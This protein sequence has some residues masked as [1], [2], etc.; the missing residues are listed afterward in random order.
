MNFYGVVE[1]RNDPEKRGRLKV[2]VFSKM[3]GLDLSLIPWCEPDYSN[4]GGSSSG[5]GKFDLPELNSVVSVSYDDSLYLP[6]WKNNI[7]ISK[8]LIEI[9]GEEYENAVSLY[10]NESTDT[11]SIMLPNKGIYSWF[12]DAS[13]LIRNDGSVLVKSN[14]QTIHVNDGIS[15][16]SENKSAQSGV[17]GENNENVLNKMISL[18]EDLINKIETYSSAQTVVAGAN[19][20][21]SPLAANL[22]TLTSNVLS[23]SLQ[24]VEIKKLIPITKSKIVTLD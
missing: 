16:G 10:Y 5:G 3:E 11:G 7:T 21:T 19:F 23:L 18:V 8:K 6:R 22:T 15:L 20:I 17:L 12:K 13:T 2:R 1:D 9:F 14:K 4:G 24:V